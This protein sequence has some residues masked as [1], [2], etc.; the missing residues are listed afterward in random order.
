MDE[1]R[2]GRE[3][4]VF[5]H[6]SRPLHPSSVSLTRASSPAGEAF[7]LPLRG[8]GTAAAVDEGRCGSEWYVF[9][10]RSRPL[11]PS[12]VSLTRASSSAGEAF[13]LPLRGR[14]L[15]AGETEEG[16][17]GSEWYVFSHRSRPERPSSV[18]ATP[19]Q[20]PRRGSFLTFPSGEGGPPQA[21]Q[22][23]GVAGVSG[24]YF[25][26]APA[27][28]A[29]PQSGL[30]PASSPVGEAFSPLRGR[31]RI[32]GPPNTVPAGPD[33]GR[34]VLPGGC[35]CAPGWPGCSAGPPGGCS[36]S[37]SARWT[38]AAACSRWNT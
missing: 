29:P 37:R 2:C 10:H 1:G 6:R 35:R 4:Y 15:A 24:T 31:S 27:Q 25:P 3:W 11:P 8:R 21:R 36:G 12:S 20:L 38:G 19:C 32:T 30:R 23:R 34:R 14:W 9:T 16:R 28:N 26:T 7:N 13:N 17:C 5:P 22:K 18:R 33:T